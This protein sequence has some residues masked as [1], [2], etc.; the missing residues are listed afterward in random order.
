M[1]SSLLI[2]L[3]LL[4]APSESL[5]AQMFSADE[6]ARRQPLNFSN[7]I[8]VGFEP[9]DFQFRGEAPTPTFEDIAFTGSVYRFAIEN[10]SLGFNMGFAGRLTGLDQRSFFNLGVRIGVPIRFIE[11][12][13]FAFRVPFQLSTDITSV[14]DDGGREDFQQSTFAAGAGPSVLFRFN[15][16]IRF[17]TSAIPSYGFSL[18]AGGFFGGQIYSFESKTRLLVGGI[19]PNKVLSLGY[20]YSFNEFDIEQDRFDYNLIG[21]RFTIGLSF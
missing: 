17:S 19:I 14:Q 12:R 20:T 11:R 9:V 7:F 1:K 21:H 18:A 5:F 13:N 16:N 6:I 8:T 10:E 2:I 4:I 15:E 3:F